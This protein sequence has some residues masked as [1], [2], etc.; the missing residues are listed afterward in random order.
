MIPKKSRLLSWSGPIPAPGEYM[1]TPSG[2]TYL[3][4]S[5]RPTRGAA[6]KSVGSLEMGRLEPDELAAVPAG[7]VIHEFQWCSRKR[8]TRRAPDWP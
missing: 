2:T 8:A 6:P 5:F 7:A 3:I 1:R 4:F